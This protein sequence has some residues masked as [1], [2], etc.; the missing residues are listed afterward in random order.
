MAILMRILRLTFRYPLQSALS[1]LMAVI[2][3]VLVLVLP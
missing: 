1:L 2:C 3:T